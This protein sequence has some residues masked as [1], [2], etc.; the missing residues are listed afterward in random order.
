MIGHVNMMNLWVMMSKVVVVQSLWILKS[1][2]KAHNPLSLTHNETCDNRCEGE[3][4]VLFL[5]GL[6][7]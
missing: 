5:A 7:I 2:G 4:C 3:S 1:V 6:W